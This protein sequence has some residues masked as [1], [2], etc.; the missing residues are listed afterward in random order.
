MSECRDNEKRQGGWASASKTQFRIGMNGLKKAEVV[1]QEIDISERKPIREKH[2]V[3]EDFV[4]DWMKGDETQLFTKERMAGTAGLAKKSSHQP[5]LPEPIVT[6]TGEGEAGKQRG[7]YDVELFTA[8]EYMVWLSRA[9]A[10]GFTGM[11]DISVNY[12]ALGTM[13]GYLGLE[14]FL[15]AEA[16]DRYMKGLRKSTPAEERLKRARTKFIVEMIGNRNPVKEAVT[17]ATIRLTRAKFPHARPEGIRENLETSDYNKVI[18]DKIRGIERGFDYHFGIFPNELKLFI[19]FLTEDPAVDASSHIRLTHMGASMGYEEEM[20]EVL[21]RARKRRDDYM[22]VLEM[23]ENNLRRVHEFA[24]LRKYGAIPNAPLNPKD[25]DLLVGSFLPL[26]G[27]E[28]SMER[29]DFIR[30]DGAR[31]VFEKSGDE[32]ETRDIYIIFRPYGRFRDEEARVFFT[33]RFSPQEKT[34]L[35]YKAGVN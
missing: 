3:N 25:K 28:G 15:S 27:L 14:R 33:D 32:T 4:A 8:Q 9:Q 22:A 2:F 6:Y 21:S 16:A 20:G 13:L 23:D 35:K 26:L 11:Q 5:V 34:R 19:G 10:F 24:V 30:R 18:S 7:G 12:L 31:D 1:S 29:W 17:K